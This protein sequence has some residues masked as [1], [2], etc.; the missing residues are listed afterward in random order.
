MHAYDF[1]AGIV[2][3]LIIVFGICGNILSFLVWTKGRRCKKLPGGIHLRA[4]AVSDTLALCIPAVNETITL[5]SEYSP[6]DEFDFFCRLE[7]VGRHFGLLV[8]SW[9][10]VCFTLERTLAMFRPGKPTYLISKKGAI[11]IMTLIFVVNFF[12]NLPYGVVYGE[13]ETPIT[14][15]KTSAGHA[16]LDQFINNSAINDSD[17]Y[18]TEVPN[19]VTYVV[20][21]KKSCSADQASFFHYLNWYHIWFMDAF[22]IFI[23]PFSLIT[24]SNLIVLFL[25]ISKRSMA[26]NHLDAKIRAVTKRAVTISISHCITSG[27]FSMAVLFPGYL[28][29]AFNVKYSQEYYISKVTLILAFAN[30]SINFLL[31]SFFGSDFRQDCKELF[32]VKSPR[33]HPIGSERAEQTSSNRSGRNDLRPMRSGDCQRTEKTNISSV[34]MEM[35]QSYQS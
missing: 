15:S 27:G 6:K 13:T 29:K 19:T 31:Y 30:H 17:N 25:I 21:Y 16:E 34:T 12:L 24:A 20:G 26:H 2:L 3:L 22:V 10:I 11:T 23:I 32:R 9:I 18:T 28:Y 33:V 35:N 14:E 8:S 7:I 1:C 4:L 5:V